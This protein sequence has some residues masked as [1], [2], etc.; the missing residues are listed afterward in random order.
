MKI[1]IKKFNKVITY[2]NKTNSSQ[3]GMVN[4]IKVK[5]TSSIEKYYR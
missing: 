1:L 4:K 5:K 2:Q 3:R